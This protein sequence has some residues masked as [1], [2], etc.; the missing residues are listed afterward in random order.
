ML[1]VQCG[2]EFPPPSPHTVL[3]ISARWGIS[4]RLMLSVDLFYLQDDIKCGRTC[5]SH[6]E[7]VEEENRSGGNCESMCT[8][9]W[10]TKL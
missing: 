7:A 8:A 9:E 5:L 6:V 2:L 3:T 1:T 4:G 10:E